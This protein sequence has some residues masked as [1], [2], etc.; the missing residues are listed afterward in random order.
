M[1]SSSTVD[2]KKTLVFL[3]TLAFGRLAAQTP[4][5][6]GGLGDPI[7]NITFGTGG[8]FGGQLAPGITNMAYIADQ[9]PNDGY[10]TIVHSSSGCFGNTWF[11]VTSD[12]T[13]NA[14][15]YFMLINASYQPSDFYVQTI[16]GLC[17]G[18][19]YQF[20]AW[21]LNMVSKPGLILP[22]ITFDIEK[23]DGT[24]LGTY[25]TG[26][27][28]ETGAPTWVQ[29]GLYFNTPPGVD[30]VVLR[31]TNN[32]SGGN[33]NDLGL[34]DITFRA[35]GPT[36]KP[37]VAGFSTDS[38]LLCESDT[39]TLR[40]N[41]TV[42]N[43][44]PTASYQWQRSLDSGSTWADIP[45]DTVATLV[46]AVT[47]PGYYEYRLTVA[48]VGNIGLV[49][50]KVASAAVVVNVVGTPLPAVTISANPD[51]ICA[52]MTV[53]F[54]A[55]PDS[56]GP[57]PTYQ[58]MVNGVSAGSGG[59]VYT[60][61]SISSTDVINCLM[62]SDAVC[63]L[64]PVAVSNSLSVSVTAIP[65]TGIAITASAN[66][67]CQDSTIDFQAVPSNGGTSPSYQWEVNGA[68]AGSD[69][70][71]FSD[72]RLNNGDVVSC[73]MQA[74]LTCAAPVVSPAITM[75]IYPLP[76]IELTTDTVIAGGHSL[77]LSPQV[78]G[79][80]S[81]YQW[82]PGKWLD[83]PE[84][85][86][87]IATPEEKIAYKLTV[88]TTN[89]CVSTATEVVEVYYRLA[90]PGAF[91]PNGDGRNDVFRVPP[92]VPVTIRR[93]A[94]YNRLG[95]CVYSGSGEGAGW[96]GR[97]DG[98]MQPAGEYVWEL[99]YENPLTKAIETAKGVVIL[100]R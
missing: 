69:S 85:P 68:A 88:V 81:S 22:N 17:A 20:A 8:G 36:I 76:V 18:T 90:I 27:I 52:G 66:G 25:N 11:D 39:Q 94:V 21:V 87:P 7:V 38:V 28:P 1:V 32:A 26:D 19:T 10:Y 44:Y 58:W 59:P 35:A 37:S 42:E 14:N 40:L 51:S 48:Q 50:C 4:T 64:S 96:D 3:L 16:S 70:A 15:G 13:G 56:G 2:I 49:N 63:V 54:T 43:C 41:A 9:C 62:T 67:V 55:T 46:R 24:V 30:T 84:S 95:A 47:A 23:T 31:M 72:R 75:L 74:S 71:F 100:V 5:C 60:S 97:F 33:G 61:N 45:G 79:T 93:L 82:S 89:G 77:Q 34:D 53:S 98:R 92:S 80:I 12:H 65:V 6:T 29:Y 83:N 99:V 91:T 57:G 73:T 78:S 86:D